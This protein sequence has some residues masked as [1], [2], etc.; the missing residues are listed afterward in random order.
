MHVTAY[1]EQTITALDAF[2]VL[3]NSLRD[4][5]H[6]PLQVKNVEHASPELRYT[7]VRPI[8]PHPLCGAPDSVAS[9]EAANTPTPLEVVVT[10]C[11]N[12]GLVTA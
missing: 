7:A 11:W 2:K 6:M 10:V 3:S 1:A 9:G 4:V 5:P 12:S 8:M